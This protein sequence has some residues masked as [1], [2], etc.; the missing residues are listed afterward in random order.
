MPFQLINKIFLNGGSDI[1]NTMSWHISADSLLLSTLKQSMLLIIVLISGVCTV[2]FWRGVWYLWDVYLWPEDPVKSAWFTFGLGEW[3]LQCEAYRG[4][5]LLG[6]RDHQDA[7]LLASPNES[8]TRKQSQHKPS[9]T[10]KR[11][12]RFI[13]I[14]TQHNED[15]LHKQECIPVGCVPAPTVAIHGGGGLPQCILGYTPPGVGLENPKDGSGDPANVGLETP[16]V[17]AWRS[18]PAKPLNFPPGS[19]PGDPLLQ[20]MLEYHLKCMLGY[21]PLLQCMRWDTTWNA[22]WDTTP[23]TEWHLQK[24]NLRK[25]KF[26]GSNLKSQS[27]K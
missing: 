17:W 26:A 18:P 2:G 19:G 8:L 16:K 10:V 4:S 15:P 3:I 6:I 27:L 22:C 1:P 5:V 12:T 7:A 21:H 23:R 25:P 11:L 24:H 9:F 13:R 14:Q 20:G